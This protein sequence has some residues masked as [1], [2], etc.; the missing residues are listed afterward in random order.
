MYDYI[1]L[2]LG[3]L[4]IVII[5]ACVYAICRE[6]SRRKRMKEEGKDPKIVGQNSSTGVKVITFI[7]VFSLASAFFYFIFSYISEDDVPQLYEPNIVISAVN[8]LDEYDQNE[9]RADSNYRG[10]VLE[11]SGVVHSI[12]TAFSQTYVTIGTG[13]KYEFIT[14][15]CYFNSGQLDTV[16]SL[17]KGDEVTIIGKCDGKSL[18]VSLSNCILKQ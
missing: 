18:N 13:E 9:V 11:V 7:I 16:A 17:N 3:I 1:L 6:M 15:Q 12:G 8:L 14:V 10:R 4:S 5:A 2:L